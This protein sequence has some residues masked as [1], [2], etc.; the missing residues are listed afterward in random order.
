MSA[1]VS[2]TPTE[3]S[4]ERLSFSTARFRI[5]SLFPISSSSKTLPVKESVS[6]FTS[7]RRP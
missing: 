1:S 4:R 3:S 5:W 6:L 2:P 7:K